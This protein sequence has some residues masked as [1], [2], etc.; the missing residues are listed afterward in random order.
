[1]TDI[2][3]GTGKLNVGGVFSQALATFQS[4]LLFFVFTGLMLG[5]AD[6]AL[7][8]PGS[9]GLLTAV[10]LVLTLV[11]G[12]V[13]QILAVRATS[14]PLGA[15]A[16]TEFVP[17]IQAALP[18]LAPV[19]L[20]S[21]L[22]GI[23]VGLGS[24]FLLI[25]GLILGVMFFVATVACVLEDHSPLE[26][27]K[28]S[29][30]LTRGNRWRVFGLLLILILTALGVLLLTMIPAAIAGVVP[31]LGALV[32]RI[33]T[34]AAEG[35]VTVFL[36]ITVTHAFLELRRLKGDAAPASLI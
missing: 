30:E 32:A 36:A 12:A 9:G 20:T 5:V 8:R 1:M 34:S 15:D 17:A 3:M 11:V 24:L 21:L 28:R 35:L 29:R 7:T 4:K 2:S 6:L 19:L 22:V 31:G 25:P 14:G 26:A 33:V 10:G 16:G 13:G 18:K 23:L 27:L